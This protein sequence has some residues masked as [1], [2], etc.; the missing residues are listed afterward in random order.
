MCFEGLFIG[1]Y[2]IERPPQP[3]KTSIFL[4]LYIFDKLLIQNALYFKYIANITFKKFTK[5]CFILWFYNFIK[6][7]G[8]RKK[9]GDAFLR[10]K[11]QKQKN[12]DICG[13]KMDISVDVAAF[14]VKLKIQGESLA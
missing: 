13:W 1:L 3:M 8:K 11:K 7:M 6:K 14:P 4:K 2:S 12:G 5:C 10:K 9:E